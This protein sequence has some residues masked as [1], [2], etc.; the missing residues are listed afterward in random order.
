MVLPVSWLSPSKLVRSSKYAVSFPLKC[1]WCLS[2][3]SSLATCWIYGC[4]AL[5]DIFV[6]FQAQLGLGGPAPSKLWSIC[7]SVHSR[8]AGSLWYWAA[9]RYLSLSFHKFY[10]WT[11]A[12]AHTDPLKTSAPSS[13]FA[14]PNANSHSQNSMCDDVGPQQ[15]SWASTSTQNEI[16]VIWC[17]VCP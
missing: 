16:A 1:L 9:F 11:L 14:N 7:P 4:S 10:P 8:A 6:E 13:S 15:R 12:S 5:E 3:L 2:F 17:G